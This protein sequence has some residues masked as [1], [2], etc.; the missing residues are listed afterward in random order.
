MSVGNPLRT[1]S[2]SWLWDCQW[3]WS[4]SPQLRTHLFHA[5]VEQWHDLRSVRVSCLIDW[6]IY[7]VFRNKTRVLLINYLF[8]FLLP[9]MAVILL[10]CFDMWNTFFTELSPV[11]C[12]HDSAP[13][14]KIIIIWCLFPVFVARPVDVPDTQYVTFMCFIR[15]YVYIYIIMNNWNTI[16]ITT[17]GKHYVESAYR[18][19]CCLFRPLTTSNKNDCWSTTAS[20]LSPC[21]CKAAVK[22]SWLADVSLEIR[23]CLEWSIDLG[24]WW[25]LNRSSEWLG[26][27]MLI[28]TESQLVGGPADAKRCLV[29]VG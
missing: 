3:R 25:D 7:V 19:L 28:S 27:L 20:S 2:N 12:F 6:Y 29:T 23:V 17:A 1:H 5:E 21:Q 26:E 11:S 10:S 9:L 24:Q 22:N 8:N 15:R 4:S 16:Q 14:R 18:T 13:R